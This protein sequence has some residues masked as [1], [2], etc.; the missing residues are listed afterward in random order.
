MISPYALVGIRKDDLPKILGQ[1]NPDEII[2]AV[3]DFYK[4]TRPQIKERCRKREI[5]QARFVAS[6]FLRT[7]TKLTLKEIAGYFGKGMTDHTTVM[8]AIASIKNQ[9]SL[10]SDNDTKFDVEE[11]KQGFVLTIKNS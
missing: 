10:K 6:Y 1:M 4:V 2:D 8:H 9:L 11:I 5:I 3:C 7:Y